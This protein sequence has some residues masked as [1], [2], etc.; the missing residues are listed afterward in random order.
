[1]EDH[2][3]NRNEVLLP[4]YKGRPILVRAVAHRGEL[5]D[6][7]DFRAFPIVDY[8]PCGVWITFGYKNTKDRFVNL[9]AGKQYASPTMQEA[10]DQL[11]RRKAAEVRILEARL[12][13]AKAAL[14]I[15]NRGNYDGI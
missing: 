5:G 10:V 8:T 2:P 1:M 7:I 15:L 4:Y 13:A 3:L 11:K 9:K 14:D 12:D 6:Y